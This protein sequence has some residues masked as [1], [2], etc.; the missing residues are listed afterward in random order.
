MQQRVFI[1]VGLF[2][3]TEAQTVASIGVGVK[4][5]GDESTMLRSSRQSV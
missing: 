2:V 4:S 3:G 1:L 5:G